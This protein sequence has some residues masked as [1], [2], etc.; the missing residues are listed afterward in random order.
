MVCAL[1]LPSHGRVRCAECFGGQA[2]DFDRAR[3]ERDGWRITNNPL[4]WGSREPEVVVLGFSKGPTQSGALAATPHD[5]VAYKGG[6]SAVAKILHHVGLLPSPNSRLVDSLIADPNGPF[7][8][9][10]LI[11]CTVER[12]NKAEGRWEGTGGSMLDGFVASDFGSGV[13][14]ACA[15]KF[16]SKLPE[17]TKIIIMF[18]LG[19]SLSYVRASKT[20]F[21][22]IRPGPWSTVNP[23]AYTDGKI[24]VVH[25]EHFKVQ[26]AHLGNWLSG[27]R[28]QR[29]RLGVLAR[30]AVS[31]ARTG[32]SAVTPSSKRELGDPP[33]CKSSQI[34]T[35][36]A[37]HSAPVP[38]K[39][40]GEGHPP[41]SN[42]HAVTLTAG[43][44][45]NGNLSLR[46]LQRIIPDGGIGGPSK[47]HVARL[48][49]VKFD[50][51][52]AVETD[53]AEDKMI[54][55]CRGAVREFYRRVGAAAGD[56]VRVRADGAR[57][58]VVTFDRR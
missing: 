49:T 13:A 26:G 10:S 55:R 54:L 17:K 45:R 1:G 31:K 32:L 43:A 23:I 2:Y 38:V 7:H 12:W 3:V 36:P 30:Q 28:H 14:E 24:M 29:G 25:T 18:G 57:T 4:A 21:K 52:D 41:L 19:T 34:P 47:E 37:T 15:Y 39:I 46:S 58:L 27:E 56:V 22:K 16:L 9:G 5:Q 53:V 48:F 20:L 44:I 40:D 8:F 50:A 42:G 35:T 6:R 33:K 11:R 51:G